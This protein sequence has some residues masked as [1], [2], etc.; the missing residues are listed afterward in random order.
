[1][2]TQDYSGEWQV[3]DV[4]IHR[5]YLLVAQRYC[6]QKYRAGLR[7]ADETTSE[8]ELAPST[9]DTDASASQQHV[10]SLGESPDG[11][12]QAKTTPA[13]ATSD[14]E[15]RI[16]NRDKISVSDSRLGGRQTHHTRIALVAL[17]CIAALSA[18]SFLGESLVWEQK[19]KPSASSSE[20]EEIPQSPLE[21]R[22]AAETVEK[23][24]GIGTG[25]DHP[26]G[27][28]QTSQTPNLT[29]TITKR[30]TDTQ[31]TAP[32]TS[33]SKLVSKVVPA[34][35]TKPTTIKGWTV[36]NVSD[37]TAVL[38]GPNGIW[39]VARG[40]LVPELG[41]VD[42]IVLWGSRWIVATSKGLI[43]TP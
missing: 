16:D 14:N 24:I 1:L 5:L 35:E 40:D 22:S 4:E 12:D 18:Y 34:P 27:S 36:R 43:T 41:R 39:K 42:S 21:Q 10:D 6:K 32:K 38:E 25:V 3:E 29:T 28:K 7:T 31:R 17:G 15:I 8:A 11:A 9:S 33:Q 26:Q 20:R 37:G 30:D 13:A 2:G 19:I 23:A